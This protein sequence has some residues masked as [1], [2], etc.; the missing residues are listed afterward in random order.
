MLR[1]HR[2]P[3]DRD[4]AQARL[5][6]EKDALSHATLGNEV[7]RLVD[8]ADASKLRGGRA[9][10]PHWRAVKQ[11]LAGGLRKNGGHCMSLAAMASTRGQRPPALPPPVLPPPVAALCGSPS[12]SP[13][14]LHRFSAQREQQPMPRVGTTVSLGNNI[15]T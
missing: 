8:G 11:V 3:F 9:V 13:L 10:E 15:N 14:S 12:S 7:D 5:V 6:A 1:L 4:P 2:T